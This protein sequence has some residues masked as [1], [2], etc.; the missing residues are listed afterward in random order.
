VYVTVGVGQ[1]WRRQRTGSPRSY[2]ELYK[3]TIV[4]RLVVGEDQFDWSRQ[5]ATAHTHSPDNNIRKLKQKIKKKF[6]NKRIA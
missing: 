5:L 2:L 3:P 1:Y 4:M 6:G